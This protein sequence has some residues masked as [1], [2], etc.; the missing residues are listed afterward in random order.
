MSNKFQALF[1]DV[2]MITG[3]KAFA[4]KMYML[5]QYTM[6][7]LL[8][9]AGKQEFFRFHLYEKNCYG[10]KQIITETR[11]KKFIQSVNDMKKGEIF[12][13]KAQFVKRFAPYI[14]RDTMDMREATEEAF[15]SFASKH[16]RFFVKPADGYFGIGAYIA[17]CDSEEKTRALFEEMKGKNILIEEL[18]KQHP[19]LRKFNESSVN[20][21]RVVTF[22][23]ADN[24]PVLID[25]AAI[26]IGRKGKNAD[27]FH[28]HG[29]GAKIDLETG[30][31]CTKGID[32]DG[33]RYVIH[34][35]SGA[36]IV[37]FKVPHWDEIVAMVK[38]AAME[39]PEVRYV[40][41]DVAI[42]DDDRILLIE[43]NDKADP[44]LAQMSD[45]VGAWPEFH[46]YLQE[47][48]ALR[49]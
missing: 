8:L 46:K 3:E 15:F 11:K 25:G 7:R 39:V 34:P 29:I 26:R 17:E 37:G 12:A 20:S 47:V 23:R 32:R 14:G 24:T 33:I 48:Q 2:E 28:H 49:K 30:I 44:D 43:G 5:W 1:S 41:W 13:D 21:F 31:V 36:Q 42:T 19:E 6:G 27:N 40:G 18:I 10:K 4:T 9:N 45:G 22:L 16:N 38:K 35:D